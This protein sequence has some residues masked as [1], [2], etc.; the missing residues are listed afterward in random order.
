V[1]SHPTAGQ[2]TLEYIA[3]VALVAALLLVAAPAVGAPG[4]ARGV[5][6]AIRHGL[7]VVGGD[8]CNL[9]DARRA[10]LPPCPLKSDTSGAEGSVTAF[11]VEVGGKWLLTVTPQSDG[12]VDV[13][14]T[15]AGSVGAV[16]QGGWDFTL[17]SAEGELGGNVAARLRFQAGR[18]WKFPDQATAERFLAGAVKDGEGDGRWPPAWK[19]F[20]GGLEAAAS[21]GLGAKVEGY[22]ENLELAGV[23]AS[24]QSAIGMRWTRDDLLTFYSR[25]TL[26][27]PEASLAFM[28][29]P[30]GLGSVEWIVEFTQGP[31]GPRE[32][33]FRTAVPSERGNHVSETVARLDLREPENL[34]IAR[35]F[36]SGRAGKDAVLARIGTHGVVE[37]SETDIEDGSKGAALSFGGGWKF[38]LSGKKVS[39]HKRL[40]EATVQRGALMGK[41][42][43]CVPSKA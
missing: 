1:R 8:I 9:G 17:G 39:V 21:A 34:A 16:A 5:A 26:S 28:T 43:D 23:S 41:R 32:L 40:V 13:V 6:E 33:A 20:E 12:T 31:D 3:A 38:G 24:A 35:P 22:K 15:A 37:R 29:S 14:R 10:G 2:A 30:V 36:L 27:G 18:G 25:T 19:S 7:C 4:I 11:S 42:L